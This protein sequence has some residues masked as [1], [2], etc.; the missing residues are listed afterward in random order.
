MGARFNCMEL[1][2]PDFHSWEIFLNNPGPTQ[3]APGCRYSLPVLAGFWLKAG[4]VKMALS[5]LTSVHFR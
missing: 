5:R 3:R 1:P 4:S 2:E